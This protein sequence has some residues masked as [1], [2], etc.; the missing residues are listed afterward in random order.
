MSKRARITL[1][2]EADEAGQPEPEAAPSRK[3]QSRTEERL[4]EDED[5][6]F[7]PAT[8]ARGLALNPGTII[9]VVALGLAAVSV[10]F[11]FRNRRP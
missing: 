4:R 6:D 8:A 3:P 5:D 9:K 10:F 7:E 2:P 11:L 1:D